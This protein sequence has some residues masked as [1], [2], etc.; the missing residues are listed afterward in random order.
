MAVKRPSRRRSVRTGVACGLG[1][2]FCWLLVIGLLDPDYVTEHWDTMMA[3]LLVFVIVPVLA[4]FIV[5][6]VRRRM[7]MGDL[8]KH[9][10]L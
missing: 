5:Y 6:S 1:G 8:R 10:R 4:V 9:G 2:V 3:C 7:W